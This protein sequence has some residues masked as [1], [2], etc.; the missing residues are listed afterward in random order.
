MT[1]VSTRPHRIPW[2]IGAITALW[3][4]LL[5]GSS[6][7]WPMGEG[8][9][10]TTHLDMAY[11]YAQD[12]FT[13]YGPG[14]LGYTEAVTRM[15]DQMGDIPPKALVEKAVLP[16]GER[17]S[18]AE[19]GSTDPVAGQPN[20]MVQHPPLAYWGYAVV[21]KVPG[22]DQLGWD[23]QIWL[24]RLVGVLMLLP[25]PALC[26][27][28]ARRLL[29]Y[30]GGPETL[31]PLALVAAVL[32][33]TLPN[34][35]RV[36]ASVNN[37]ALLIASSSVL[38]YLLIRVMTGDLRLRVAGGVAVCLAIALLTKGYALVLPLAVLGSYLVALRGRRVADIAPG[39]LVT[40]LG[41][42]VGGLWYLRN[43]VTYGTVQ[44]NGYGE[45]FLRSYWGVA[46]DADDGRVRDFFG[47]YA[48]SFIERIWGGIGL[49][50]RLTPGAP[51]V[52]GWF[53][54][55]AVGIAVAVLV[56]SEA[57][58]Q[59]RVRHLVPVL[60]V[61]LTVAMAMV[62]SLELWE[63]RNIGPAAAQGRYLYHLGVPMAAAVVVGWA[64]VL[65]P[66]VL[67]ALPVIVLL[68]GLVTDALSWVVVLRN[69]YGSALSLGSGLDGLW[70]WSPLPVPLTAGF[71]IVL[72]A[73]AG[74][75]CLVTLARD[76][77]ADHQ[78]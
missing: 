30:E 29:A 7:I 70:Q 65:R 41:G 23:L 69:W 33:L 17:P 19:L 21:L 75:V 58:A 64:R 45:A 32:P 43:L 10:E 39:L 4:A 53:A 50:D 12:P 16:R 1:H 76:Q 67:G 24:L 35:A 74:V 60:V 59:S 56:R 27:A 47:Q 11:T 22:F 77:R 26:W 49:A 3:A 63:R 73:I 20:Q 48:T 38:L 71:A 25:L 36:I 78:H 55:A 51:I 57:S 40:A 9:D 37:D 52:Y 15:Q 8:F 28:A 5:L 2:T 46:G 14:E 42:A 66:A 18:L 61:L 72:P 31:E 13:F 34:L 54:L 6:V 44:P 62:G 68:L